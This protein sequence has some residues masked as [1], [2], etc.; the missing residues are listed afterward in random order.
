[1]ECTVFTE[2]CAHP[3]CIFTITL[4]STVVPLCLFLG[5]ASWLLSLVISM[6][7]SGFAGLLSLV[8]SMTSGLG[9]HGPATDTC[10]GASGWVPKTGRSRAALGLMA[11]LSSVVGTMEPP[12]LAKLLSLSGVMLMVEESLSRGGLK[13]LTWMEELCFLR[14]MV[15]FDGD[16][17][18][19][20][21][22]PLS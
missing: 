17:L 12:P 15:S 4:T 5:D 20:N 11:S 21:V 22:V 14:L 18:D 6:T 8:M 13:V 10:R 1:M 3:G 7:S 9:G 16:I 19:S 2:G